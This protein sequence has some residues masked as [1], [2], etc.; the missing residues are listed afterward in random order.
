[1]II[2]VVNREGR[3]AV[4]REVENWQISPIETSRDNDIETV[5]AIVTR[6]QHGLSF[7]RNWIEPTFVNNYP[8]IEQ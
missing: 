5:Q 7:D 8:V 3:I 2:E 6:G 1:M 4:N